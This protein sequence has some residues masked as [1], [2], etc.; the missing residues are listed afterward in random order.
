MALPSTSGCL[1]AYWFETFLRST[2]LEWP[3]QTLCS[4]AGYLGVSTLHSF[5]VNIFLRP[6]RWPFRPLQ[7]TSPHD[8]PFKIR[9]GIPGYWTLLTWGLLV[10]GPARTPCSYARGSRCLYTSFDQNHALIF[11]LLLSIKPASCLL[12]C[13]GTT[14]RVRLRRP[15][16]FL[17]ITTWWETLF[18]SRQYS[19]YFLFFPFWIIIPAILPAMMLGYYSM[20]ASLMPSNFFLVVSIYWKSTSYRSSLDLSSFGKTT[21]RSVAKSICFSFFWTDVHAIRPVD[22]STTSSRPF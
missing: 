15:L 9:P 18:S 12:Q 11:L 13:S 17:V 6:H 16:V 4:Y 3:C 1:G 2:F 7:K 5:K 19:T 21:N 20:S 8:A 14:L 10:V 22:S